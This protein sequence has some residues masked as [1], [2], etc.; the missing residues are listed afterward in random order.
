V[1][2]EE[3]EASIPP[4]P[5]E[6]SEPESTQASGPAVPEKTYPPLMPYVTD[7]GTPLRMPYAD[8]NE[9]GDAGQAGT[10]SDDGTSWWKR[11]FH[12]R[13]PEG[14]VPGGE[15]PSEADGTSDFREDGHYHEHY[16]G[17]PY[18]GRC[19]PDSSARPDRKRNGKG[20]VGE[21][22][23]PPAEPETPGKRP[24]SKGCPAGEVCPRHPEV[25]TM[26]FRPSDRGLNEYGP[27]GPL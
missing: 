27:G 3:P 24:H 22:Q 19:H 14:R 21:E 12:M 2:P 1:I 10:D 20:E 6:P 7:D 16:P 4:L 23:E 18:T 5:E 11:L 8:E 15:E 26:E 17:C 13:A 25:D 9:D